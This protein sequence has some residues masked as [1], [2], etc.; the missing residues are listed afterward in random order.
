MRGQVGVR[1]GDELVPL[2]AGARIA[3]VVRLDV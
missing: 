3:E 1:P 2:N